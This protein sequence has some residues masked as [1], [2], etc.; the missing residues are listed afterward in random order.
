MSGSADFPSDQSTL[1]PEDSDAALSETDMNR[2]ERGSIGLDINEPPRKKQKKSTWPALPK[3]ALMQLN[4]IKPGLEFSLVSQTGAV[5]APTFTMALEVNGVVYDGSATTKKK[6]K[7]V[8]AEKFLASF[9][10][11]RNASE[12]HQALG[13]Q[14][15]TGDFTT[16]NEE[17]TL[18]S[19]FDADSAPDNHGNTQGASVD[20][21]AP[22]ETGAAVKM[23]ANTPPG[24]K[25]PVMILNEIR[26]G[27]KYECV[28]ETG[29]SHNK[30]FV[31]SVEVDG[32]TFQVI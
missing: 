32:K 8:A 3:N 18:F 21:E 16:D 7:L 30:N 17:A 12:A 23:A 14:I 27:T 1:G 29:D 22:V 6:A 10:Q 11:F 25:N 19:N 31:M 24:G 2:N 4:E 13:R 5:H 26:P 9:V 28:S 15:K 20:I